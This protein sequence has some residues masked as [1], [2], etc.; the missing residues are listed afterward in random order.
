MG[1]G[2]RRGSRC[3]AALRVRFDPSASVPAAALFLVALEPLLEPR[4]RRLD[5]AQGQPRGGEFTGQ[6][7]G[8]GLRALVDEPVVLGSSR[9][10][11]AWRFCASRISGAA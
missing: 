3:L 11:S 8:L 7:L 4:Q 9:S 1:A 6:E 2:A 10:R 5:L